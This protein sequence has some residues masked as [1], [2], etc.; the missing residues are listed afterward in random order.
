[1]LVIS[2]S[3]DDDDDDDDDND[4]AQYNVYGTVIMTELLQEFNEFILLM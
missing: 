2:D 3:G 4:E 1:M